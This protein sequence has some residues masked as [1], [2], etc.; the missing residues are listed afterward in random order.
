MIPKCSAE[1]LRLDQLEA[2]EAE[3]TRREQVI[4]VP[5]PIFDVG[6]LLHERPHIAKAGAFLQVRMVV[7]ERLARAIRSETREDNEL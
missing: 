6:P 7:Q 2:S 3:R 5:N 4:I 1:P